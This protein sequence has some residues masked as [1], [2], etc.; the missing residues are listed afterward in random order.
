MAATQWVTDPESRRFL[1]ANGQVVEPPPMERTTSSR[2]RFRFQGESDSYGSNQIRDILIQRIEAVHN[3]S[4]IQC[5]VEPEKVRDQLATSFGFST[6][7]EM[8][9]TTPDLGRI[10]PRGGSSTGEVVQ[11]WTRYAHDTLPLEALVSTQAQWWYSRVNISNLV[12]IRSTHLL[13]RESATSVQTWSTHGWSLPPELDYNKHPYGVVGNAV[14]AAD[15]P[16]TAPF[17]SNTEPT[18]QRGVRTLAQNIRTLKSLETI[19]VPYWADLNASEPTG[20]LELHAVETNISSEFEHQLSEFVTNRDVLARVT[21]AHQ[22]LVM[23]MRQAGIVVSHEPDEDAMIAALT[24]GAGRAEIQVQADDLGHPDSEHVVRMNLLTGTVVVSC[25]CENNVR[26]V[27]V[28]S[29]AAQAWE[30]A[31]FQA[32]VTGT[33]DELLAF[34]RESAERQEQARVQEIEAAAALKEE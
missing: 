25:G 32:E 34:A 8:A 19:R 14:R 1:L 30:V 2:P 15:P 16:H 22:D 5:F 29:E 9:G 11:G 3:S 12:A 4:I 20:Y 6:W 27:N 7:R 21:K 17:V 28:L 13:S 33:V 23:T 18:I 31:R 10:A 26:R 24:S